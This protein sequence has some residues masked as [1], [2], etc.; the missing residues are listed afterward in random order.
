MSFIESSSQDFLETVAEIGFIVVIVGVALEIC[1]V[2][3]RIWKEFRHDSILVK[4][5]T[6]ILWVE[7]V[8]V[9]L[10]VVGLAVEFLGGLGASLKARETI[11]QLTVESTVAFTN[12]AVAFTD[13]GN[14]ERDAGR[15]KV[16]AALIG[17]TNAE[18]VASN[19]LFAIQLN[20]TKTQLANAEASLGSGIYDLNLK[21]LPMDIGD[22]RSL[23]WALHSLAGTHV[24][25]QTCSDSKAQQTANDL[26]DALRGAGWSVVDLPT[27]P[28]STY[29]GVFF[30]RC[31][32]MGAGSDGPWRATISLIKLLTEQNVPCEI[33]SDPM[34]G[35]PVSGF[36]NPA[37]T[38]SVF[39][40]V[41]RRP[42]QLI[43]NIMIL[44]SRE[45]VGYFEL[46][47]I[48]VKAAAISAQKFAPRSKEL[49]QA[50]A[51]F[52]DLQLQRTKVLKEIIDVEEQENEMINSQSL[53]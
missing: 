19:S 44:R 28:F 14:A 16:L 49:E 48:N 27:E 32:E 22:K 46:N 35:N 37:V 33:G 47:E 18:L 26:R 17:I 42:N 21:L 34:C 10:V 43:A 15:A 31:P 23:S 40:F 36:S 45:S 6:W 4:D 20:E 24:R 50:Q 25:L 30:G 8:S 41:G 3:F 39:I 5:P 13:A 7:A 11:K 2:I 9:V 52:N 38:N 1:D 12:A 53:K 29:E 51:E